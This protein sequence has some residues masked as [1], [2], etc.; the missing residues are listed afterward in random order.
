MVLNS[1]VEHGLEPGFAHFLGKHLE[2]LRDSNRFRDGVLGASYG[3]S[4]GIPQGC[5]MSV[6]LA[7]A[8]ASILTKKM[9]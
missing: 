4:R 6:M 2:A 9:T 8:L 5:A 3:L 7:N 1:L